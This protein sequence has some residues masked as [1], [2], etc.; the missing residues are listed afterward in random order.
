MTRAE[1]S[2]L[3]FAYDHQ[4]S[5]EDK[6]IEKLL[7]SE[8]VYSMAQFTNEQIRAYFSLLTDPSLFQPSDCRIKG[9]RISI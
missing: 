5:G 4:L 1:A 8:R 7:E 6:Y 9:I 2:H 3:N